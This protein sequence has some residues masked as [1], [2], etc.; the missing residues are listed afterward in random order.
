METVG[1]LVSTGW[2][3]YQ[4]HDEEVRIVD[5][6]FYLAEPQ[7]GYDEYMSAHIPTAVYLSLDDHLTGAEGPGRHPLPDPEA[8]A[9]VMSKIGIGDDHTVV[10]YDQNGAGIAARLWWMLRSLGHSKTVVLDGGWAAWSA[11][12]RSTTTEVPSWEPANM[13][14][15]D[16]W[17]GTIDRKTIEANR[18]RFTLLDSRARERH[19]GEIEPIDPI[20]GHIPGS[21][22]IPY[23][24]NTDD[25][26]R[27]LSVEDLAGRFES[28]DPSD[29]VVVYCGSGVTA[30]N[31]I[32]A[33]DLAG[34]TGTLLYPG[35][36]SDWS[37]AGG[38]VAIATAPK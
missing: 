1:P 33:M 35:S 3:E 24:G 34:I 37:G 26:G 21:F 5:C 29:Q 22:N 8:F 15:A 36:W 4:L 14:M 25:A 32:L 16:T 28:I 30:C 11:E 27:F 23:Q 18:D 13:A 38:E 19:R 9:A 17:S 20:S 10:V 31:N 7:R 6:R 12:P 2:L